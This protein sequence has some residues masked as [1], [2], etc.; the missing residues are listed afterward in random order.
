MCS[1]LEKREPRGGLRLEASRVPD[2]GLW[3]LKHVSRGVWPSGWCF[4]S[5]TMWGGEWAGPLLGS[6]ISLG[7]P[8]VLPSL[9]APS[10]HPSHHAGPA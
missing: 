8:T 10:Q 3:S 4:A 1:R 2:Q 9:P 6:S 5:V 7:G